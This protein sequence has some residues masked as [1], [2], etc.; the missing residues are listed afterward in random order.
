MY[1]K[2]LMITGSIQ[3]RKKGGGRN[4][5]HFEFSTNYKDLFAHEFATKY[6]IANNNEKG[7]FDLKVTD[8][9]VQFLF[10]GTYFFSTKRKYST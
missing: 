2:M 9:F 8:N 3:E 7:S 5:F 4:L 10:F 6:Y 1:A